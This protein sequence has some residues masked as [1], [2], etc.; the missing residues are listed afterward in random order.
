MSIFKNIAKLFSTKS[1][2][3]LELNYKSGK[4]F[5]ELYNELGA[6]Q[7]SDEGFT[8]TRGDFSKTLKWSDITALNVYKKDLLTIDEIRME[9]VYDTHFFEIS[10]EIPGW[11]Q[12]VVKTKEIFP[13]I[14]ET[15]DI[16]IIQPPFESNYRT[17]YSAVNNNS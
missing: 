17:I 11:Y 3:D 13:S 7:Y 8:F 5:D 10:E 14:P 12:F 6:F 1:K 15:W 16:E 2:P 4:S 9:I